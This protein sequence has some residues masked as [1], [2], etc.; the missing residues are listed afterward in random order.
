MTL[1]RSPR[2][3]AE[4]LAVWEVY[5]QVDRINGRAL[6]ARGKVERSAAELEA[7]ARQ[8]PCYAS[9]SWGKDSTALAHLVA[10]MRVYD[11]PTVPLVHLRSWWSNPDCDLV[12][13]AFL[14]TFPSHPYDEIEVTYDWEREV[15]PN[16]SLYLKEGYQL[17]A[18]R[19]GERYIT[20]IRKGE[21]KSRMMRMMRWG[22]S[23]EGTCAPI[24]WWTTADVF[25]Y[26]YQHELPVHPAYACTLGGLLDRES[27]RVDMLA[28]ERGAGMGRHEWEQAYYR[29]ELAVIAART[30][31]RG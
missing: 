19:H 5:E 18:K 29:Q 14:A 22:M 24:G 30:R 10:R 16:V 25:A 28:E 3:R 7:F 8:G 20:G 31:A 9:V 2:H 1:V 27:I 17:A 23:T 26:L 4:D 11:G 12:R 21:S 6:Y 13:D 15:N